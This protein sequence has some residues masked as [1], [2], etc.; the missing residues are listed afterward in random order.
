MRK[1]ASKIKIVDFLIRK[2]CFSLGIR[3]YA[4]TKK[5]TTPSH[6]QMLIGSS[7]RKMPTSEGR[8]IPPPNAQSVHRARGA[9]CRALSEVVSSRINALPISTEQ[10]QVKRLKL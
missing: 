3:K 10:I 9:F 1:F 8:I 7:K 6:P 2:V 5:S 4:D